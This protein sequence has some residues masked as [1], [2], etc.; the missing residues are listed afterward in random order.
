MG[1]ADV[2]PGVSGGTVALLTGIYQRLIR[3][4]TRFDPGLLGLLIRGRWRAALDHVDWKFLL[5]LGAGIVTGFVLA[6]RTLGHYLQQDAVR[7]I[8]LAAFFGMVVAA[9]VIVARIIGRNSTGRWPRYVGLAVAGTLIA[10]AVAQVSPAPDGESLR[11]WYVFLGGAIGICAMILPGISGALI[12]LLLGLYEPLIASVKELLELK[13]MAVNLPIFVTF[14]AG[15]ASGL[16]IAS[17]SLRWMLEH[18]QAATLS[19]LCGLM[20]G[21]LPLLW[22]WQVALAGATGRHGEKVFR[23]VWPDS[24]DQRVWIFPLTMVLAIAVVLLVDGLARRVKWTGR[25]RAAAGVSDRD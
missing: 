20:I 19:L 21:S 4:I 18:F 14:A 17:R 6:I 25:Q 10:G 15:A 1:V 3:A 2:I 24:I 22:P 7:G 5:A 16:A 13:N 11:L 23:P 12:L 8:I 9:V